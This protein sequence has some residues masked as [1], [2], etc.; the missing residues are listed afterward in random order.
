[1]RFKR[2]EKMDLEIVRLVKWVR[3]KREIVYDVTYTQN[4]KGKATDDIISKTET[5][6]TDLEQE[7]MLTSAGRT[8]KG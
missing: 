2:K 1:M 7:L 5:G 3:Q 8:G 4:L 6:F